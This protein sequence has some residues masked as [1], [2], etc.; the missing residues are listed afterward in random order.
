MVR[1][2]RTGK[3]G[4]PLI[5]VISVECGHSPTVRVYS[6][7]W[8]L[9]KTG[10]GCKWACR[11]K[12]TVVMDRVLTR[13]VCLH[14]P[15]GRF[16]EGFTDLLGNVPDN[17]TSR[18]SHLLQEEARDPDIQSDMK[19]Q[20]HQWSIG[21]SGMSLYFS[22]R[23]KFALSIESGAGDGRYVKGKQNIRS[24][25][26]SPMDVSN[27]IP[28]TV[29]SVEASRS[30]LFESFCDCQ[31]ACMPL[32]S[33]ARHSRSLEGLVSSSLRSVSLSAQAYLPEPN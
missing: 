33:S 26:V 12:V 25:W 27:V 21:M 24:K 16:C 22:Q 5:L 31:F 30:V 20:G 13:G 23:E 14:P 11:A 29:F 32:T 7:Y 4:D 28:K 3:V 18:R 8:I 6:Q 15:T 9:D 17:E 2:E 10:F 1:F 19:V